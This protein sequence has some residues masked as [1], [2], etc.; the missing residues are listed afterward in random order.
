[1]KKPKPR[2]RLPRQLP[3]SQQWTRAKR[4]ALAKLADEFV[5]ERKTNGQQQA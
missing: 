2:K 5:N 4:L 1:M 3:K